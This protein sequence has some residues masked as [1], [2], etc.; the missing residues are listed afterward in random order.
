MSRTRSSRP[1]EEETPRRGGWLPAL[2]IDANAVFLPHQVQA[3]LGLR[4]SSLR[5]EWRRGRLRVIR[6]CG[7]NFLL[8]RDVLAWLDG[9]ELKRAAPVNGEAD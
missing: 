7:R 2:V 6:R 9:G 4:A 1:D 5:T 8:G 3:A